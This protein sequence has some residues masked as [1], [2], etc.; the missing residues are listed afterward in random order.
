MQNPF[1]QYYLNQAS[2]NQQGGTLEGFRGTRMQK[3]YG[4]GSLFKGFA[5]S[6][7]PFVKTG[8]KILGKNLVNTGANVMMDVIDGKN[9]KQSL[10]SRGKQGGH[11]VLNAM[12]DQIGRGVKRKSN[13]VSSQKVKRKRTLSHQKSI[14]GETTARPS[15]VYKDIFT[16]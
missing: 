7:L 3:G 9:L 13:R 15:T 14:K 8:A 1:E 4:L 12:K 16:E 5:R 11:Q 10:K 2:G 6:A